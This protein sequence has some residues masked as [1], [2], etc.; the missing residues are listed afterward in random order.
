MACLRVDGVIMDATVSSSF[1]L[2]SRQFSTSRSPLDL[3]RS[4]LDTASLFLS[5]IL[6]YFRL[7]RSFH[8]LGSIIAFDHFS[9][10]GFVDIF[11]N[12]VARAFSSVVYVSLSYSLVN[13]AISRICIGDGSRA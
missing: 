4:N 3:A 5:F 2:V 9:Y 12:L 13:I 8:H 10:F 7:D 1:T 11:R 6:L